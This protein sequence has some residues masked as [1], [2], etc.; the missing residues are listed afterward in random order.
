MEHILPYD[1]VVLDYK[2]PRIN[3]IEV[4]KEILAVNPRQRIILLQHITKIL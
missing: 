2:I 1:S 4:G 3:A